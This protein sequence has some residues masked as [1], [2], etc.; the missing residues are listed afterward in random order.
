MASFIRE[1]L[2][3]ALIGLLVVVVGV[4]FV[5]FA[6][7]RTGGGLRD[8]YKVIAEFSN[9]AGVSIGTDVRVAGMK[10]GSV[11]A[12]R[13]DPASYQAELT[14]TINRAVKLPADSSAAITSEGLMGGTYISLMPGGDETSL[15]EGD[16]IIDT[17]GSVDMLSLIGQYINQTG[18]MKD[19][20]G[21]EN[22]GTDTPAETGASDLP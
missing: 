9:V 11:S 4:W 6:Y 17:Q 7:G 20:N 14:L 21:D 13:I 2:T 16:V 8:G 18:S 1:N 10:V 3:E 12:A 15:K 22:G 19:K 5:V